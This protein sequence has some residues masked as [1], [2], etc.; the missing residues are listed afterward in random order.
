MCGL[1]GRL[2]AGRSSLHTVPGLYGP[3]R[4]AHCLCLI[5]GVARRAALSG[6]GCGAAL[7]GTV[8]AHGVSPVC[9]G[10]PQLRGERA[11][12][13]AAYL[14]CALLSRNTLVALLSEA[15]GPVAC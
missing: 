7:L 14:V 4:I 9:A 3:R 5:P 12:A 2:S 8:R 13:E 15:A 11:L 10:A 6:S 1:P